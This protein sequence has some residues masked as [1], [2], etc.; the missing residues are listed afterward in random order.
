MLDVLYGIFVTEIAAGNC[1]LDWMSI[2]DVGD[3][4]ASVFKNK[5]EYLHKTL[6]L[7]ANKLSISEITT[8]L[9]KHLQPV[10]FVDKM[11]SFLRLLLKY[12]KFQYGTIFTLEFLP[13]QDFRLIRQRPECN[14]VILWI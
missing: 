7:S 14:I 1:A 12:Y 4:I 10:S 6:S 5:D 8:I 2:D 11:V 3:V 13:I 9:T